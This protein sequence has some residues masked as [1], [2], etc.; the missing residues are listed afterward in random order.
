[1]GVYQHVLSVYFR[2]HGVSLTEIGL[3]SVLGFAWTAKPLWSPLVDRFGTRQDW[4]RGALLAMTASLAA[5]AALPASPIGP[6][7]VAALATYCIASATQDIAIDGYTIGLVD[8][9]RE[10]PANA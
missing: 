3:L 6:A 9:G 7:L 2:R 5:V 4:I 10:G 1:M 8:R